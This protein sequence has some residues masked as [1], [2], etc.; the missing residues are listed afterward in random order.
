MI[1]N[2]NKKNGWLINAVH[3]KNKNTKFIEMLGEEV[4]ELYEKR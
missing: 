3:F 1:N 4:I 2:D